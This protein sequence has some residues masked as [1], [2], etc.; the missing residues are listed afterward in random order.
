MIQ[1]K[2]DGRR[3]CE[4]RMDSTRKDIPAEIIAL[5]HELW[6]AV[7]E[8]DADLGKQIKDFLTEHVE[9]IFMND[10]ELDSWIEKEIPNEKLRALKA[11]QAID[12]ILGNILKSID[13]PDEDKDDED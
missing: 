1:V 10:K 2:Y 7:N 9:V 3:G 11:L 5:M 8:K 6:E 4:I 12:E 13:D